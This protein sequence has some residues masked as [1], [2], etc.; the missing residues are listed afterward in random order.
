MFV[1]IHDSEANNNFLS[2]LEF[3]C[4]TDNIIFETIYNKNY[5][6][7]IQFSSKNKN[8][9]LQ[10]LVFVLKMSIQQIEKNIYVKI[11][12]KKIT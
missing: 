4:V 3:F 7:N 1:H 9:F 11:N 5:P 2:D 6:K 8:F 12:A 10:T